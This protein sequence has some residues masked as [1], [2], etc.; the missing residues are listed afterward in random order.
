MS[1]HPHN[2]YVCQDNLIIVQHHVACSH[3]LFSLRQRSFSGLLPES[4]LDYPSMN[5]LP[6]LRTGVY[7]SVGFDTE[8]KHDPTPQ[9]APGTK[10]LLCM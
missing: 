4:C 7:D 2:F 8:L 6:S 1:K 9:S 5:V 3:P 10:Y